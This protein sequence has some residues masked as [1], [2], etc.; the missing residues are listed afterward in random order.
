[1]ILL[2]SYWRHGSPTGRFPARRAKSQTPHALFFTQPGSRKGL[3]KGRL[4]DLVEA[5]LL[6]FQVL[7]PT[8]GRPEFQVVLNTEQDNLLL[9]TRQLRQI[10]GYADSPLP[11]QLNSLRERKTAV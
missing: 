5:A 10:S 11:I 7:Q 9:Q 8:R 3:V 1:M 4:G 2:Y 6:V